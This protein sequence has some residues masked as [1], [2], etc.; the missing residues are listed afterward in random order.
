MV[1]TF[2]TSHLATAESTEGKEEKKIRIETPTKKGK[3]KKKIDPVERGFDASHRRFDHSFFFSLFR[4]L[5]ISFSFSISLSLHRR[6]QRRA[7]RK[8]TKE[9][10]GFFSFFD[11][12]VV[13][14]SSSLGLSRGRKTA[15]WSEAREYRVGKEGRNRSAPSTPIAIE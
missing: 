6:Y 4:G 5:A 9:K 15:R 8:P 14:P 1:L 7:V 2:A 10:T 13:L 11:L 12:S 3:R